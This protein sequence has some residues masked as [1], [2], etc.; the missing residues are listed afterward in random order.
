MLISALCDYYNDLARDGK[1]VPEGYS[2]QAV[3]YLIAL[4]PDGTIDNLINWQLSEKAEMKNGKVKERL[5]PR[6]I[7]LPLRSEK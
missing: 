7:L 6:S 4:N 3:H 2:K 1:V 5:I